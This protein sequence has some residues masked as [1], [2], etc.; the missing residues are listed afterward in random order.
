M[1]KQNLQK[2]IMFVCDLSEMKGNEWMR[3]KLEEKF[4]KKAAN[5]N[6]ATQLEEIYEFCLQKIVKEHADKFYD[7]FPLLAIKDKLIEDFVRMEKFRRED[8]FE[9][10][11][12]AVY[13]QVESIVN[14]I[15]NDVTFVQKIKEYS[16]LPALIK[17]DEQTQSHIRKGNLSIGKLVFL[18]K[19]N[20]KI[21]ENMNK[22]SHN[23][24]FNH[25]LRAVLYFVYFNGELK[26]SIDLF[27]R[28]YSIG[29]YLYQ[30]RNLNHRGGVTTQYQQEVID[31]LLPNQHKYYFKFMGF[32]ED[33][34]SRINQ[35]IKN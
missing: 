5:F 7:N 33:F 11:C 4:A 2:L 34:V 13:Q 17:Y 3:E 29:N 25:K 19:E 28:V 6:G 15:I 18:T 9:D 10:F 22:P 8:N 27:D 14:T 1:N 16:S 35:N 31:D 24:Y 26:G 12:L 21:V 30:G 23:W 20:D 32:L